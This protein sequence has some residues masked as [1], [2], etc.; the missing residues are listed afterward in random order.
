[1]LV[2]ILRKFLKFSDNSK[3]PELLHFSPSF[4]RIYQTKEKVPIS[5]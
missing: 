5:I 3:F 2:I 4:S 1:M